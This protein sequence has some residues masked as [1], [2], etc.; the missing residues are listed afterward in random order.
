MFAYSAADAISPAIQRTRAFLFRPFRLGTYLKFCLVALLTEGS[1]GGGGGNF[2]S[3]LPRHHGSHQALAFPSA[4]GVQ[5]HFTPAWIAAF[6]ALFLLMMVIGLALFYLI[7]RLRFAFFHCLV[8]NIREVR[9]GWHL[10]R[11][12]AARFFWMNVLVGLSFLVL[13]GV[14]ALPFLA[15]FLRLFHQTQAGAPLNFGLLLSLLLPLIPL[16][17][18]LVVLGVATDLVL[19]DF[20]LPHYAL[21]NA[22]AGE[23]WFAVWTRIRSEKGAFFVYALLRV[24]LPIVAL[25]ALFV[26]LIIPAL[27]FGVAVVFAEIAI[28]A[29]FSGA[30]L[31]ALPLEILIGA[32]AVALALLV[33]TALWGPVCT[34]IRQYALLFYG[35]RYQPLN[36]ILFPPPPAPFP[37][38]AP[39]PPPAPSPA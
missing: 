19:R 9:I 16:I 5:L 6:A 33:Y 21:E 20:M 4:L 12:P 34:A 29:A 2:N 8:Y 25:I 13:A 37:P 31:A 36:A 18:L 35:G 26:V 7:T 11:Y 30:A 28:H 10:Y 22:T 3:S 27:I 32:I 24:F 1:S 38:P 14:V 39:L 15:G 17:L 23:A